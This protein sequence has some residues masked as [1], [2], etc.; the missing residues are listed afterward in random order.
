MTFPLLTH[1]IIECCAFTL[2]FRK[3]F[4]NHDGNEIWIFEIE[5]AACEAHECTA[6]EASWMMRLSDEFFHQYLT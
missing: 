4:T 2:L 3:K 5:I 1:D 6:A